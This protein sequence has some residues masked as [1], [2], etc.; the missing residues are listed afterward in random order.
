MLP[1]IKDGAWITLE[2]WDRQTPLELSV[3]DI[4]AFKD[5]GLRGLFMR[6]VHRIV[7]LDERRLLFTAKGDNRNMSQPYETD[8]PIAHIEAKVIL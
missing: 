8:V 6:H 3:G 1:T 7:L 2:K 4:V 5:K